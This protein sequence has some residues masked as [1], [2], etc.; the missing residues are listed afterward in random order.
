M[1]V[2]PPNKRGPPNAG[3]PPARRALASISAAKTA[4]AFTQI[5][6]ENPEE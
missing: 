6:V 5:V 4:V 3:S 1:T 2:A